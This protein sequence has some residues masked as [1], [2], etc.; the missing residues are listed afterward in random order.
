MKQH[1][2][3]I[4]LDV[5]KERNGVVLPYEHRKTKRTAIMRGDRWDNCCLRAGQ[6]LVS[7]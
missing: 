3:Y 7:L 6:G 2:K 1:L 4:G 5:H